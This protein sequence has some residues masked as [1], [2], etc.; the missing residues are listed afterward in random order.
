MGPFI[1]WMFHK[2]F[3]KQSWIPLINLPVLLGATA[4]MPPA[5]ALN[6]NSWIVVGTIFNFFVFRYRK[7]WWQKYNYIL[8]AA[9][10]AG[11]AFM[12]VLLYFTVNMEGR[13]IYWWGTNDPE[14]CDLATC[15]T[16]KGITVE[17]CP[18]F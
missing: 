4:A 11:V 9:L 8:S 6:Y 14:H 13:G 5:S 1:V 12:A 15:P 10:D 2:A 18:T 7:K 17:G 3:P 16:A